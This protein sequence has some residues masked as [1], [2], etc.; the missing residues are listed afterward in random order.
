MP[1]KK[2]ITVVVGMSGGVDSSVAAFLLKQQGYRVI[3]LFM[4]N[5]DD[6][7]ADGVCQSE[8]DYGDVAQVCKQ[9]GIP[10]FSVNY[11]QEY[12]HEVFEQFLQESREGLTPNPDILCNREIKFKHFLRKSREV[13]GDYLATGHYCRLERSAQGVRL[14]KG[15]DP[16]KDQSY[17]VHAVPGSVLADVLFP[18]GHLHKSEV[19]KIA[20]E[21]GFV[22]AAKKDSTGICFVGKRQFRPFLNR[23]IASD[24]GNFETVDGKILGTHMGLAFY[25]VGQRKGMGIGGPGDAWFIAKKDLER[26]VIIVCQGGEHPALF[27]NELH[28]RSI[29]WSDGIGPELPFRCAAKV[30]YRQEDQSCVIES[31][32]LDRLKVSFDLPQRAVTPGQSVV[33]YDGEHCLGGAVIERAGPTLHELGFTGLPPLC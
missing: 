7:E 22:N 21:N 8:E 3:G 24:P 19:R 10:Y 4:K 9:I 23:Y 6:D 13:G 30:R 32:G 31:G 16:G 14:C 25:T 12:W 27:C 26:N 28:A 17:F 11:T 15:R 29:V 18:I 2:D 5:W 1:E 33:F 20:Q